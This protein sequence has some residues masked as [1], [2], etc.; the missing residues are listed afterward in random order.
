M[1]GVTSA[2]A[3]VDSGEETPEV[4]H[5]GRKRILTKGNVTLAAASM[6]RVATD[7]HHHSSDH[8]HLPFDKVT[9]TNGFI[10]I[11]GEETEIPDLL[12]V[13]TSVR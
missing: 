13:L 8:E 6:L 1:Y 5:S 3:V 4:R 7:K 2:E 9:G 12:A 11:D 10:T